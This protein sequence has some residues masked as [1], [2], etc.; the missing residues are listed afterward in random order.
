M[1]VLILWAAPEAPNYGVRAL[2]EGT[3]ALVRRV[4]PDAECSFHD[5]GGTAPPVRIGDPRELAREWVTGTRGLRSWLREFDLVVDT[6][7][8]D[9]FADIYGLPRLATMSAVAE[10]VRRSGVPLVLGPQTIGPFESRRGRVLGRTS[11]R[12][13][14]RTMARD[15]RSAALAADLGHPVDARTTD[16]VFALDTPART[17]TRD[18]VLNVSGLLWQGDRHVDSA[19]YRD[20]VSRLYR[21]LVTRGREVTL[22]AHV[23]GWARGDNDVPAVEE[24]A[25]A[26]EGPV[27]VV[28]PTSL[29]EVREVVAGAS[30]VLGSRMHACLNALSVGTPA[31]PLAYSRKFEPLL[32]DLGW[33]HSVDL[34][35]EQAPLE[36]VL[37][38]L[39]DEPELTATADDV[40]R[41]AQD[42][43]GEAEKSLR[44]LR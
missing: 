16:V 40:R 35:A 44:T 2:A 4:W 14:T 22:L 39:D 3:A 28:V 25:A 9:S 23:V 34:R 30:L 15:H 18:V 41:R 36:A 27:D 1:R 43:L 6:R 19:A 32:Q 37:R 33:R 20:T 31:V 24:F 13:A 38:V 12:A 11:L 5:Y 29:A 8:G 10:F 42:L 21:E 26:H 7:S 17:A